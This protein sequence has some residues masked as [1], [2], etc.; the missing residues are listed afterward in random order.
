MWVGNKGI[1]KQLD[2]ETESNKELRLRFEVNC[3]AESR[4][5]LIET[6]DSLYVYSQHGHD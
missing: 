3:V 2:W 1:E 5:I 6:H 4:E